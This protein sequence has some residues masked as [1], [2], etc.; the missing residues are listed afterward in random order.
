MAALQSLSE[1][2]IKIATRNYDQQI[3]SITALSAVKTPVEFFTVQQGIVRDGFGAAVT[4]GQSIAA[5]TAAAFAAAFDPAKI[6][7]AIV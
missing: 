5:L 4:D 6:R 1:A 2:Y 3:A 7:A